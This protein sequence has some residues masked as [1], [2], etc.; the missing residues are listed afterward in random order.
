MGVVRQVR[1][2]LL[3]VSLQFTLLRGWTSGTR[4]LPARTRSA[5]GLARICRR[6]GWAIDRSTLASMSAS[7]SR[8]WTIG[9]K[10]V[11]AN[12]GTLITNR[13]SKPEEASM[14]NKCSGCDGQGLKAC[15]KC[16]GNGR[17]YMCN[18]NG[19]MEVTP[20]GRRF[21]CRI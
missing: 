1:Q 9:D 7:R 10:E 8:L 12:P 16:S 11:E 6:V 18:G 19:F 5:S 21:T 13:F 15:H 3:C 20:G 4:L 2:D 17:C 14:P